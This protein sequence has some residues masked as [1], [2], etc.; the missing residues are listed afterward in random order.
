M[1]DSGDS[2]ASS[3]DPLVELEAEVKVLRCRVGRQGNFMQQIDELGGR[4]LDRIDEDMGRIRSDFVAAMRVLEEKVTVSME[5]LDLMMQN[6]EGTIV[7][8]QDA[9][10]A[11][12]DVSHLASNSSSGAMAKQC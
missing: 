4:R 8:I 7:K 2:A 11:S 9:G 10:N 3:P 12:H 5:N 6:M 1:V